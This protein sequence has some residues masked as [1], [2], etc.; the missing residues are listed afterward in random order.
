[1]RELPHMS[2]VRECG[3]CGEVYVPANGS[4]PVCK[5]R[6]ALVDLAAQY[7]AI[8]SPEQQRYAAIENARKLI[9]TKR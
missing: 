9:A 6:E 1:V 3:Q 2:H 7:T 8:A 4:C 5:A